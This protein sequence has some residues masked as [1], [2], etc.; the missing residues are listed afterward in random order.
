MAESRSWN[1]CLPGGE[2]SDQSF[3]AITIIKQH[4]RQESPSACEA[5]RGRMPY[6]VRGTEVRQCGRQGCPRVSLASEATK[7]ECCVLDICPTRS[8]VMKARSKSALE[9]QVATDSHRSRLKER[10]Y[11]QANSPQ[12]GDLEGSQLSPLDTESSTVL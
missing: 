1:D 6:I 5:W 2:V 4:G 7:R 12:F 3:E 9:K 11:I 8:S 10:T